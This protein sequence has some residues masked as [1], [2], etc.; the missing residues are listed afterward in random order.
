[1]CLDFFSDLND[2]KFALVL[3]V[4][5]FAMYLCS[6]VHLRKII[7]NRPAY[8]SSPHR[9]H[10]LLIEVASWHDLDI[11]HRRKFSYWKVFGILYW[12]EYSIIS[13]KFPADS[14]IFNIERF[15]IRITCIIVSF[16]TTGTDPLQKFLIEEDTYHPLL[17]QLL[18][19]YWRIIANFLVW[20]LRCIGNDEGKFKFLVESYIHYSYC[21]KKVVHPPVKWQ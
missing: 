17:K 18:M 16:V 7:R 21:T 12:N 8:G 11:L 10:K 20:W 3:K 14:L 19:I 4:N 15:C 9:K 13:G 2:M 6:N 1:M 5:F